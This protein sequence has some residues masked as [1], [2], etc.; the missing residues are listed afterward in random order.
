MARNPD[1]TGIEFDWSSVKTIG[2][3][4]EVNKKLPRL[5]GQIDLVHQFVT[6]WPF[7]GDPKKR[8]D[9]VNLPLADW[10]RLQGVLLKQITEAFQTPYGNDQ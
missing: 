3:L 1:P 2:D 6:K 5:E 4:I 10:Q 8:E 9:I 7:K